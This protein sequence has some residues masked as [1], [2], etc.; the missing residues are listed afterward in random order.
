MRIEEDKVSPTIIDLGAARKNEVNESFLRQ[1]GELV[2]IALRR[3]FG[4][5]GLSGLV[6]GTQSEVNSFS[7]TLGR[8]KRYMQSFSDYGL[9][10]PRTYKSKYKLDAAVKQFERKTGLKWPFK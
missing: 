1:F 2:K 3:M 9:N 4:A 7:T 8:E 10:D 6:R 5:E